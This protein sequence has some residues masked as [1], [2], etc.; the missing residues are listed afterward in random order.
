MSKVPYYT[1]VI[2]RLG[3]TVARLNQFSGEFRGTERRDSFPGKRSRLKVSG[4][5]YQVSH[6]GNRSRLKDVV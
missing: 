4:I 5:R 2:G 6:E 3:L 1:H